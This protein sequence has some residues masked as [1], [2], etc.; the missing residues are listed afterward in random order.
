MRL[1]SR[2]AGSVFKQWNGTNTLLWLQNS[3]HLEWAAVLMS[4]WIMLSLNKDHDSAI[5]HFILVISML[6]RHSR[7]HNKFIESN[8]KTWSASLFLG[9]LSPT[10]IIIMTRLHIIKMDLCSFGFGSFVVR[11]LQTGWWRLANVAYPITIIVLSKYEIQ[12]N[13]WRRSIRQIK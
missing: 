8:V 9:V 1:G 7:Q 6:E 12:E 13:Q 4:Q 11:V 10:L 2:N 3:V 5:R